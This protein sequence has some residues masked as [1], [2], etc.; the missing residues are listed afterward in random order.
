MSTVLV[1][2]SGAVRTI[3]LNRPEKRNALSAEMLVELEAAFSATPG[4]QERVVAL[5]SA[6][7][8]FCAGLDLRE[9]VA[10]G[11]VR[12]ASPIETVLHLVEH[13]P[14][15]VVAV[16]QGDA[17]AG[18]NELAL[19]CDFVVASTAARFGMSLA[20]I[21]LAPTWFLAKKLLEVAGPVAARE[22]LLL[23][24]PVPAARM[25]QLGIISRLAEPADLDAAA[26]AVIERLAANAPLSLRAMKALLVRE[27]RFREGIAHEDVDRL[28]DVARLSTDAQEG[29][30]AR[31]EKRAPTFQGR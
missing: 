23:G 2:V 26:G 19:H 29:I 10:T 7:P 20:Q 6:G 25:H 12:G 5:R 22:I 30:A 13:Y 18:G 4:A 8:V 14:L 28:V 1:E 15:P 27:M 9:R 11:G 21:G 3:T 16:V 17:I 24:D 31:L